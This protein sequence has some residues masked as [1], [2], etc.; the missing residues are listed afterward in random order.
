VGDLWHIEPAH[1][2]PEQLRSAI[3][4]LAQS[5]ASYAGQ[6]DSVVEQHDGL[7]YAL[8]MEPLEQS[9]PRATGMQLLLTAL[10]RAHDEVQ[11]QDRQQLPA[12][13]FGQLLIGIYQIPLN[14][15]PAL[16]VGLERLPDEQ[17]LQLFRLIRLARRVID[18]TLEPSLAP[19]EALP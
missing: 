3:F 19:P 11:W 10:L 1:D 7:G 9:S 6:A 13:L 5:L 14:D 12:A 16:N 18:Q 2:T 15:R 8:R 4:N 17:L